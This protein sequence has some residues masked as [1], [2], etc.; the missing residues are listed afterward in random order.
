MDKDFFASFAWHSSLG[1]DC[2]AGKV[3]AIK[4]LPNNKVARGFFFSAGNK[5]LIHK[6][7][8]CLWRVSK[9]GKTIEPVFASD[10]LTEEDLKEAM[11]EE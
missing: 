8:K 7:T 10:V 2:V 9:D 3:K 5:L 6:T 11:T 4:S 1:M